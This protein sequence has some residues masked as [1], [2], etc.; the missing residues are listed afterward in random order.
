MTQV[1]SLRD[2]N[3]WRGGLDS[4]CKVTDYKFLKSRTCSGKEVILVFTFFLFFHIIIDDVVPAPRG[5][6]L[7]ARVHSPKTLC[8]RPWFGAPTK[9]VPLKPAALFTGD[10]RLRVPMELCRTYVLFCC[11]SCLVIYVFVVSGL[12]FLFGIWR[13]A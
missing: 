13:W 6:R 3:S 7:E 10:W 2:S 1:Y 4:F 11:P 12:F 5:I 8:T 9:K